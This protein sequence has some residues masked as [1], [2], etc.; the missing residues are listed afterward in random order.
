MHKKLK[1]PYY[2]TT[3]LHKRAET[4]GWVVTDV[5]NFALCAPCALTLPHTRQ[6]S[7][8]PRK[9]F[10][11]CGMLRHA[12]ACCGMLRHA[13]ACFSLHLWVPTLLCQVELTCKRQIPVELL[14]C[15]AFGKHVTQQGFACCLFL[16]GGGLHSGSAGSDRGTLTMIVGFGCGGAS[17]QMGGGCSAAL[18]AC[19]P[20]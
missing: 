2:G 5:Q 17:T 7:A 8:V 9:N 14:V 15:S 6:A 13:A 1:N 16:C 12:A 3:N 20:G 10:L 11:C 19:D 18:R 4:W